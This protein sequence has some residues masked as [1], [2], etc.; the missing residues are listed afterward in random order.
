MLSESCN[1]SLSKWSSMALFPW[2]TNMRIDKE[3]GSVSVS[4]GYRAPVI[5]LE[6]EGL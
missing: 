2:K 5:K 4:E 1:A 6:L 3:S